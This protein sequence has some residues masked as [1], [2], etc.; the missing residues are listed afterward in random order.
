MSG[1]G[2]YP[3]QIRQG[4]KLDFAG[5]WLMRLVATLMAAAILWFCK[6]ILAGV[7]YL[8]NTLPPMQADVNDL[9]KDMTAMK[10][11]QEES[12]KEIKLAAEKAQKELGEAEMRVKN[13]F[14]RQLNEQISKAKLQTKEKL[15]YAR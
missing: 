14:T 11:A 9:K 4:S 10:I 13:E 12:K 3:F 8:M 7:I 15:N 5:A 2:Y 1:N 6:L